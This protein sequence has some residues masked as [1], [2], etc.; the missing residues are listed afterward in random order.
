[1]KLAINRQELISFLPLGECALSAFY[2]QTLVANFSEIGGR[3]Q[4][5]SCLGGIFYHSLSSSS[6][7]FLL[8]EKT[9]KFWEILGF[10]Y[11]PKLQCTSNMS[12][13]VLGRKY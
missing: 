6:F 13:S 5:S 10:R 8:H 9:F 4:V 1:M 3:F 11:V 2:P 7:L 12:K